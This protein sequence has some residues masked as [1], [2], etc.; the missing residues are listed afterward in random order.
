MQNVEEPGAE[1]ERVHN[2]RKKEPRE[3]A[4]PQA[5]VIEEEKTQ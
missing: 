1:R 3:R 5:G 4:H 2:V